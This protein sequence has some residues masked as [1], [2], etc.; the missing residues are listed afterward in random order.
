MEALVGFSAKDEWDFKYLGMTNNP[1]IKANYVSAVF[2]Y[3][4]D[5][6]TIFFSKNIS[7]TPRG[8]LGL[9]R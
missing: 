4:S 7:A 3:F 1:F 9:G 8:N 2:Q 6:K 5:V